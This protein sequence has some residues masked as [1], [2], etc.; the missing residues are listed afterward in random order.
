MLTT[1]EYVGPI[2]NVAD[3]RPLIQKSSML[4][5]SAPNLHDFTL[6]RLVVDW[7]EKTATLELRGPDGPI[8]FE[9]GGLRKVELTRDDPWGPSVSVNGV[10]IT[11]D[12]ELTLC[13]VFQMQTG[14][15]IQLLCAEVY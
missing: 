15:E 2:S 13:V 9:V 1:S 6:L 10:A 5:I 14:D 12:D 7:E 3:A 11:R 4:E 8:N